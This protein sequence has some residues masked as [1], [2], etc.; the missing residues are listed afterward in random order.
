MI[1]IAIYCIELSAYKSEIKLEV[2][3][4]RKKYLL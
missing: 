3:F 4:E 1:D 2:S